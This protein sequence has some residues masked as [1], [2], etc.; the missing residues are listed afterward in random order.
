MTFSYHYKNLEENKRPIKNQTL[1]VLLTNIRK[2]LSLITLERIR[3]VT[4]I[5]LFPRQ[6]GF[7]KNK[8]SA[9]VVWTHKWLI[10]KTTLNQMEIKITGI[11]MILDTI[12]RIRLL[13]TLGT[14][15]DE[16]D[17]RVIQFLLRNTY[18]HPKVNS[19]SKQW[20]PKKG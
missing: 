13:E 15:I 17:L 6:S 9:D 2:I 3:E 7:R 11:D 14:F 19:K 4:E 20:H 10:A 1:I 8:R 18:L 5:F 16:D 12:N